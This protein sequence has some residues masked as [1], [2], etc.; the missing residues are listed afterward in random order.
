MKYLV[1]SLVLATLSV[2]GCAQPGDRPDPA[3]EAS[4][5][6][7]DYHVLMAEIA[8]QRQQFATA[9]REY[10]N[11]LADNEDAEL[12]ARAG[13]VIYEHGTY[14]HALDAA[15]H[16]AELDPEAVE[17]RRYLAL[18]YLQSGAVRKA[19]PH[20][21]F[22]HGVVEKSSEQGYA[23]LLPVLTESRDEAAALEA[24]KRLAKDSPDDPTAHYALGY[25]A[26]Q[27]GDLE[28]ALTESRLAMEG[29]PDWPEAAVLHA[30][31]LLSNDQT[32]Q[33]LALLEGRPDFREDGRLRLEYAILLL[34][35]QR[36]EEARLELE[37]LLADF[38]RLPGALRTM[39]FLEFQEGNYDLAERYFIDLIGTGLYVPDALFYLGNIAEIDGDLDS[40]ASFYSQV[41]SGGNLIP[42]RVRLS[43]ILYR[44]GKT[45]EALRSLENVVAADPE[46]SI[47]LAAARGELLMRVGR[48]DEALELYN[49]ELERYPGDRGLLFSRSFLYERM[50][51]V[52]DAVAELRALL[53]QDPDDPVALNALGYTLA[54]RT[55]QHE[56]AYQLIRRAYELSPDNAAIVDS[57]GWVEFRMGNNEPAIE[58]L[59][60]AWSL[61]RDP[62]IAAHLG[63]VLWT[64]GDLQAA[65]EIWFE[66]LSENPESEVLQEV[67]ERLMQ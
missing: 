6:G 4:G 40:A 33:G 38:P 64:T 23:A 63:E 48:F 29:R 20:L 52:D 45:D 17:P 67:I 7:T 3:Q 54:D 50:D 65:E 34:A 55:D 58:Y 16:W 32:E 1:F 13:R 49:R 62:E 24:M 31:A 22:L 9:A 47:D 59:R 43:L 46:S 14:E 2:A 60:R 51:R 18:L 57:M 37:L 61:Q 15:R 12:A 10:H 21:E 27:T 28:L 53:A 25:L 26:L 8:L 44:L 66:A 42:A 19:L 11:A 41:T 35:A 36:P 56:E 39:G 30:R 5:A